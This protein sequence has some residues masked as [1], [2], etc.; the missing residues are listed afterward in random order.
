MTLPINNG[1]SAFLTRLDL[2]LSM[3]LWKEFQLL[4]ILNGLS[5]KHLNKL[6]LYE[7]DVKLLKFRGRSV[8]V[9]LWYVWSVRF[10]LLIP[11][12]NTL[13]KPME[14]LICFPFVDL[15]LGCLLFKKSKKFNESCS[16]SKAAKISST[17]LK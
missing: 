15:I 12:M 3:S 7:N 8:Y 4:Q 17:Y 16:L 6:I 1:G 2:I 10:W 14:W 5:I 11:E 13:R 9:N